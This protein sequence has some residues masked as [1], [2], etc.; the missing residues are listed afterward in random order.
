MCLLSIIIP[1]YN[2]GKY[3]KR[4]LDSIFC[5]NSQDIE[6]IVIDDGSTDDSVEILQGYADYRLKYITQKNQGVSAARNRGIENAM[7]RY[8][9]FCDADDYY[10]CDAID[11]LVS[12]IKENNENADLFTYAAFLERIGKDGERLRSIW[13]SALSERG[14]AD[15][16]QQIKCGIYLEFVTQNSNMN[17]ASNKA[18]KYSLLNEN[19]IR[20]PVGLGI[21]EDGIFNLLCA[22]YCREVINV[23]K[24]L[25]VYCKGESEFA[26]SKLRNSTGR[27]DETY[28]G[29]QIRENIIRDYC[30]RCKVSKD[31]I[32]KLKKFCDDY[33]IEQLYHQIQGVKSN[34]GVDEFKNYINGNV[35][36]RRLVKQLLFKGTSLKR[37]LQ[38]AVV[39]AWVN[40]IK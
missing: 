23:S 13:S 20:F 4:C 26:S 31:K 12:L 10:T 7:G 2:N 14:S 25:Y 16:Q 15:A 1:N 18:Y 39:F 38:S 32:R 9:T 28:N 24:K 37:K 8:L 35:R 33:M 21:G 29:F 30:E 34:V 6:V 3:L 27:L 17:S 11:W 5:A 19:G 22:S 40:I 36:L